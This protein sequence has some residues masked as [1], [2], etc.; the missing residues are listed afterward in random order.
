[1]AGPVYRFNPALDSP[2]KLPQSYYNKF[3]AGE[4]SLN[5]TKT[6]GINADGSPGP[7]ANFPWTHTHIM[8]VAIGPEGALYVLD[9]GAGWFNG[10]ANSALYRVESVPSGNR[11]PTA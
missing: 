2:T 1:M 6:V 8:D 7:V 11:A 10:D 4:F 5:W 9:Y 3:C